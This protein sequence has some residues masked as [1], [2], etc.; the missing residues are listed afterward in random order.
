MKEKI[1][2]IY[3]VAKRAK[4]AAS[5]VSLA[6]NNSPKIRDRTKK[7]VLSAAEELNYFPN[8]YARIL[9]QKFTNTIGLIVPDIKNATF[10][11]LA[12][13]AENIARENGYEVLLAISDFSKEKEL[14]FISLLTSKRVDGLIISS[15][16]VHNL[17]EQLFKIYKYRMAPIVLLG[18]PD[19]E[20]VGI[21]FVCTDIEYGGYIAVFHLIKLGH[22]RIGFLMGVALENL[23]VERLNGYKRALKENDIEFDP[24]LVIRTG[25][26]MED[27]YNSVKKFLSIKPPVTAVFAF[28]DILAISFIKG[29]NDMKVKVPDDMAVIGFDNISYSSYINPPLTTIEINNYQ[30]GKAAIKSLLYRLKNPDSEFKHIILK[31]ELIIRGSC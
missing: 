10:S 7:K 22:K 2:N 26:R 19:D 31:P 20:N 8:Y 17:L 27:S 11:D 9:K 28:N 23:A 29:L 4:V 3:D 15:Q 1:V 30:I 21:D 13:I 6:F 18:R 14:E 5:T 24:D 25:Y 12:S 16:Y